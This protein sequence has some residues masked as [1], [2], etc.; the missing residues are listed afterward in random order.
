MKPKFCPAC[1]KSDHNMCNKNELVTHNEQKRG[2]KVKI[3]SRKRKSTPDFV[4]TALVKQFL[5]EK[6]EEKAIK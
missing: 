3:Y 1:I 6:F 5:E 2:P 4:A